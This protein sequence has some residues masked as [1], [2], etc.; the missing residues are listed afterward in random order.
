MDSKDRTDPENEDVDE[1]LRRLQEGDVDA[2]DQL[3][4]IIYGQLRHIAR[5]QMAGQKLDHT[6]Q[7]TALVN[8]AYMRLAKGDGRELRDLS[9]FFRLAARVMRQV[10]VDHARRKAAAKRTPDGERV[11]LDELVEA[12]E[13]RVGSLVKLDV[14]LER[15]GKRE[16]RLAELVQLR[17]FGG[18]S[19]PEVAEIM[20][21]TEGQVKRW[22][23]LARQMLKGYLEEDPG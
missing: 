12:H 14:A 3:F 8:E 11:H 19:L 21:A 6:L 23:T 4:P 22:W 17:F 5:Q 2:R 18:R 15:L 13:L 9:H 7:A 16:P 20:G 10:L 1:L